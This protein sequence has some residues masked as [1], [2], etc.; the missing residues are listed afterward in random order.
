MTRSGLWRGQAHPLPSQLIRPC[1]PSRDTAI[2]S[3]NAEPLWPS[4]TTG[5]YASNKV[6]SRSIA[7]MITPRRRASATRAFLSPRRRAIFRACICQVGS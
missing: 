2:G 4:Q 1:V 5:P 3:A 7:C 6:P